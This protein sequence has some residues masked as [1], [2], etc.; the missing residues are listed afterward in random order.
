[1]PRRTRRDGTALPPESGGGEITPRVLR[2]GR[3]PTTAGFEAARSVARTKRYRCPYCEG[4]I[5][6]EVA[7][8]VAHPEGRLDERRHFHSGCWAKYARTKRGET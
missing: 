7:H 4:W 1:M 6:P 2:G 3:V 8:V 5:E